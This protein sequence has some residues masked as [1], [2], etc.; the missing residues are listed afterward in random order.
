MG[1]QL[2]E[3]CWTQQD[4]CFTSK[5][6]QASLAVDSLSLGD[7]GVLADKNLEIR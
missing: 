4:E 6:P 7:T 1:V 5:G 3:L 2:I